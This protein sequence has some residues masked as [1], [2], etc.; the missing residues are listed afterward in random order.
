MQTENAAMIKSEC[1][2]ERLNL[3][4]FTRHQKRVFCE[5]GTNSEMSPLVIAFDG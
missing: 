3:D 1:I 4:A 5:G 2:W